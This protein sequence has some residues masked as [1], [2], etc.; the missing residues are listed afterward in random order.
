MHRIHALNLFEKHVASKDLIV[1][2][3]KPML[4][5]FFDKPLC[6]K[7]ETKSESEDYFLIYIEKTAH[8][9]ESIS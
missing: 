2:N 9:L 4:C 8:L 1:N 5:Q 7:K 3:S 6:L